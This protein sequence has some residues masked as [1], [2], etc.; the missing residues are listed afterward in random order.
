[1]QVGDKV[2]CIKNTE[3]SEKLKLGTVYT[4]LEFHGPY[5]IILDAFGKDSTA[6]MISRF[7]LATL[8]ER[9]LASVD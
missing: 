9:E 1:M 2:V 5:N 6:Y 8:L 7:R 4:I 3:F